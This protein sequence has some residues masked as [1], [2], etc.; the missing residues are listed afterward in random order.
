MPA[1]GAWLGLDVGGSFL[2]AARVSSAGRLEERLHLP[3]AGGSIEALA[4]QLASAVET[5]GGRRAARAIGIGLP[6]GRFKAVLE[7]IEGRADDVFVH[8]DGR[9]IHPS[10]ITVAAKSPCFAYPGL[11]VFRDYQI[12]QTAPDRVVL[13]VVAGRDRAPFADCAKQGAANLEQLLAPGVRV[14]LETPARLPAG[15]GG[16]RKIF[17]REIA[18]TST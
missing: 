5:L 17:S 4:G 10:K 14:D 8:P 3:I 18:R 16:K 7:R 2:K 15:A 6:G 11:Q 1:G 12:A 13:R 9:R